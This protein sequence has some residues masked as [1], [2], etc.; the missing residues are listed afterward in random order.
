V[1]RRLAPVWATLA[2]T[3]ALVVTASA[4]AEAAPIS[5]G[6]TYSQN[7][8][9]LASTGTSSVVP[10][11]WAFSESGTNAN[12]TY[13]AGTGSGN[14]GDT[15]SFGGLGSS[16]RAFGTLV[17]GSLTPTIGAEFIN[18]TGA[19]ITSLSIAYTGEQWRLGALDR[20]AD[21]LF[22]QISTNA[23]SLTTGTWADVHS[24][25]F[26]SP[27][28]TGVVGLRDGNAAANRAAVTGTAVANVEPGA[29]F[30][31]RFI[32]FNA[33]GADDGLAVD[34]F[35]MTAGTADQAPSVTG[36]TPSGGATGVARDANVTINFNEPVTVGAS[37]YTISCVNSGSHTAASSGGPQSYTLDPDTDFAFSES[38]TVTVV[39]GQVSDQDALDPPDTMQADH[40]FS[41][42]TAS[43]PLQISDVQGAGHV[44]PFSDQI[45][46]GVEGVVTVKRPSSF[47]IQDT[48]PDSSP[49][50]SEGILVFGSAAAAQVL[51]GDLVRVSGRV[52]EFRGSPV[53]PNDLTLTEITSPTVTVDSHDNDVPA[54]VLIGIGGVMPPTEVIDD[55]TTGSVETGTTT[56]D[57]ANDGLD[58]WES[59]EGMLL[60]ANNGAVVNETE[61]FGEITLLPDNGVWAT[62]LRT[63]RGG[64]LARDDYGDF[65][66]ERFTVDDEILRDQISP[67]P[68]RAMPLMN[69]GDRIIGS[70]VGPLDYSFSNFKIQA[71]TTPTFFSS[72]LQPETAQAPIDQEIA[73]ATFNVE[74]L[75]VSPNNAANEAKFETLAGMIVDNLRS[76]DLIGIEEVQDDS[77][78]TNNGVVDATQT[79]SK[80]V[81]EIQDAGGP[82]YEFR[83]INPVN[84]EDG[85][86]P[87]GNIRVGFLFR[88][89]RGLSFVDRP[90]GDAT[91]AT[92][93]V[94]TA[95]GPVMS[96]S[97]GRV[98]PEN[99]AWFETRKPVVGEFRARGKKLF[100]V[101]NHFS[102]KGD[103]QPLMGH[104]QPPSRLSE[105][106]NALGLG[107]RHAQAQVVNDFVN[108]ILDVDP[109]ADVI[110]LGDINDFEFSET[111]DIL[112]GDGELFS[113]IKTLPA[114]ERYSYVFEGNSQVLDQILLSRNIYEHFLYTYD[115]VHVNSEF[116]A[117]ASDH[118]PAVVRI[119]LTGRPTLKP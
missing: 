97:P 31:I 42:T 64:I 80:L 81:A 102:S 22:F 111:V 106:P 48:T 87:G 4:P 11:G 29:T 47:W 51:V 38:C 98:D 115:V 72:N 67:R 33:P 18:S 105:V 30:W 52:T 91:T 56:F 36:T 57:P 17:S 65:N 117:Q 114:N 24:L 70:V 71:L 62:G 1:I 118:E 88:T 34:D 90:G 104:N 109:N 93:V 69:V 96:V 99:D 94:A 8:D 10:T 119:N 85:G 75:S 63:P 89:D 50:T 110:V 103:D 45:V 26:T 54:P 44:S 35:S 84:N 16:E 3:V 116:A 19:A 14:A 28:T 39:A 21:R 20:G 100:V 95:S 12:A 73:V 66:P 113:A 112:E 53:R 46:S 32:D 83:S 60:Q 55:D 9:S 6:V 43:P 15:Y 7:F 86:A 59:Y 76:P 40:V 82:L 61:S 68:S 101:V 79:W 108:E 2:V 74:N 92:S 25:D 77:G 78:P 37:W 49:S 23:T 107:G 5:L 27:S 41:F 58:F 13:T